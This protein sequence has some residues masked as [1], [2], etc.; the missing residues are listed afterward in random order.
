VPHVRP[1]Q[2]GVHGSIKKPSEFKSS[3]VCASSSAVPSAAKQA[4]EKRAEATSEAQ[5]DV[6]PISERL[7][8]EGR[9][10]GMPDG[11][12]PRAIEQ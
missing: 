11:P 1:P 10:D 3:I 9:S 2:A 5:K 12:F 6:F 8:D 4:A 7:A